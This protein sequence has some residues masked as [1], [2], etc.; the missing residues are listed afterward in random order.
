MDQPLDAAPGHGDYAWLYALWVVLG[1]EPEMIQVCLAPAGGQPSCPECLVSDQS[2]GSLNPLTP[3]PL[4][5]G[6]GCPEGHRYSSE[7]AG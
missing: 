1:Y 7:L 2:P 4:K 3:L 6:L 5:D